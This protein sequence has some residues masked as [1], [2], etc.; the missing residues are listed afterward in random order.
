MR[1]GPGSCSDAFERG[2]RTRRRSRP[3]CR[4]RPCPARARRSRAAGGRGRT[5]RPRCRRCGRRPRDSSRFRIA[6]APVVE[7]DRGDVEVLARLRP[8]RLQ[9]VHR[10]AVGLE[11]EHLAIGAR[12]RGAGGDRHALADRAPGER[13]PVVARRARGRAGDEQSAGLR[14]VADDRALGQQRADRLRDRLRVERAGR[15]VGPRRGRELR[16]VGGRT[17][18]VGE[19][20]ERGLRE[21]R[22]RRRGRG[23]RSL[24]AR[25]GSGSSGYAKNETGSLAS[26]STR[27]RRSC[28]CATANSARYASR[29]TSGS[30]APRSRRAGNVSHSSL[31]PVACAMRDAATQAALAQRVPADEQRRGLAAAQRLGRELDRVVGRRHDARRVDVAAPGS[32]PSSHDTSAGRISVATP[33]A[34]RLVDRLDRVGADGLRTLRLAHP[35]RDVARDADD[36]GRE[37]RV[38]RLVVRRVIA[39][40]VDDR[41]ARPARVVQVR[42]PVAEARDRGATAWPRACRPCGRSR[43]RRRW[44][45]LRTARA[46]GA[47]RER[48][49]ARRRSASP[50][51]PGS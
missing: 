39:D 18:R 33:P 15:P 8:Q 38:E 45:R 29:S 48:R 42:E 40:D 43:R 3:A 7:D 21:R 13:Q 34:A 28:I 24:P 9:R 36:V 17:D 37:R 2:R 32:A 49:R 12:D 11:V 51:C 44:R 6:Y 16:A 1:C 47:S 30:P 4:R 25:A 20:L 10:A 22:R 35:A 19:R 23:S 26:T 46:P 41:R 5:G 31:A 27:W 50:T 14:L